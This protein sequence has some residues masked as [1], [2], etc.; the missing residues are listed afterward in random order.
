MI[1]HIKKA[2]FAALYISCF[3][4]QL[5][6]QTEIKPLPVSFGR[7][8]KEQQI[9]R[10]SMP[11]ADIQAL[12]IQDELADAEKLPYRF[13]YNHQ[14]SYSPTNSGQW[15]T[16]VN[17]ERVWRLRIHSSGAQTINLGFRSFYLQPGSRLFVYNIDHS[18]VLGPYTKEQ[19]FFDGEMA[20]DLIAADE[21]VVELDELSSGTP[22]S[23]SICRVTHGYR[24]L[25]YARSFGQAGGCI[26]NVN[27]PE[28]DSWSNQRRSVICLVTGGNAFCSACLINNTTDDGTPYILTANHCGTPSGS[29]VFRFNWES[30]SCT[31]PPASPSTTQSISG[32]VPVSHN[33]NSDFAL[34]KMSSIPPASFQ[35]FY[36]G[37]NRSSLPA[38]S[39]CTIHHPSGDIKKISLSK[40]PVTA[41]TW[42]GAMVWQ[43]GT[44]TEGCTESGSSG[45]PLFDQQRRVVGQLYS[46]PSACGVAVNQDYDFFG[47]FDISW[48][49]DTSS[50]GRLSDWLDPAHSGALTND[51]YDPNGLGIVEMSP[52]FFKLFPNPSSGK[53]ML[54]FQDAV[55]RG[56]VMK[57]YD[58][59][60]Q[61][62][63]PAV[64]LPVGN[65]TC[66]YDL[67]ALKRGVYLL[68]I[69]GSGHVGS[70][71]LILTE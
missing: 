40:N 34:C 3:G 30:P 56:T 21:V 65:N 1:S 33:A 52:T 68:R 2:I 54:L 53:I 64:Y 19:N 29:W 4:L 67:S 59:L 46:G 69:Q 12:K 44:W 35:V 13:G 39:V 26:P 5:M 41:S 50:Q 22:S 45:A 28:G 43:T 14:V 57:L 24:T 60:G 15:I 10:V 11:Y 18:I 25:E 66:E 31:N 61:E 38:D 49:S 62:A 36:A 27:C 71:K 58:L 6:S 7:V 37:W 17:G 9:P 47:R 23:F 42:A 55:Q 32:A 70:C 63:L 20:T 8:E 51:G 48:N 16:S